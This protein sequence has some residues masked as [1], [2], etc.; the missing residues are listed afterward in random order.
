MG[1]NIVY[2]FEFKIEKTI[3]FNKSTSCYNNDFK[4]FLKIKLITIVYLDV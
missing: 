2:S 3:V 4:R 1:G